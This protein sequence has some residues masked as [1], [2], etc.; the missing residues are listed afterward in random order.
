MEL[1]VSKQNM[2]Q[3]RLTDNPFGVDTTMSNDCQRIRALVRSQKLT[4]GSPQQQLVDAHLATCADCTHALYGTHHTLL[5]GLLNPPNRAS[6]RD[7]LALLLKR[8]SPVT[9]TDDIPIASDVPA[10]AAE[11]PPAAVPDAP[12]AASP[13]AAQPK[14]QP[15]PQGKVASTR[16]ASFGALT[17]ALIVVGGVLVA[18]IAAY[19]GDVRALIQNSTR[20]YRN[21]GVISTARGTVPVV[22][23]ADARAETVATVAPPQPVPLLTTFDK[24]MTILLLGSDRRPAEST[25]SRTDAI[26]LLAIDPVKQR[27]S[28]LSLPRDLLVSIPGYGW[29]RINAAHVYGDVYPAL[30]GGFALAQQ[31]IS[32][33]VGVPI[34]YTILVDFQGFINVIDTLGGVPVQVTK[35]LYD[36]RFP[37]MDYKFR[38]V[39][40]EP[41]TFM[42]DGNTTLTYSRIRHPDNDFERM[43][44]QQAVIA[45]IANQL[46]AGNF[47]Q[48]VE[49]TAQVTDALIGHAT[50]NMPRDVIIALAWQM[51]AT[52]GANFSF[53]VFRDIVY[54]TGENRYAMYPVEG[55]IPRI[56]K[57]WQGTP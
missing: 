6:T 4:P 21:L 37:T 12:G 11:P 8:P 46:R 54:G 53:H 29:A 19:G 15:R 36:P 38:E 39:S 40:F 34:D 52:P 18:A 56:V 51:R 47:L 28:M 32:Q 33:V 13:R 35:S 2:L 5:G 41:G 10:P 9:P 16:P 1:V 14:P 3:W 49:T 42:M 20:I 25:P 31:T 57:E 44:R 17:W 30:G 26:L 24:P 50:T 7:M 22:P 55:A 43:T 45:G 27:I 23:T 48:T